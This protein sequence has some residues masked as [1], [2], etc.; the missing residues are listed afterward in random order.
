MPN[1]ALQK[2]AL[3]ILVVEDNFLVAETIAAALHESGYEVVGPA[4]SL[5]RGMQLAHD[6]EIDGALLDIN[7][8]G[9]FCFP[10]ASILIGREVPFLFLTGYDDPGMI[11]AELRSIVRLAKPLRL[12]ELGKAAAATFGQIK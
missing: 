4:P 1:V 7:L 11:P 6:A 8:S 9:R 10:I 3:R 12:A 2:K 5:A